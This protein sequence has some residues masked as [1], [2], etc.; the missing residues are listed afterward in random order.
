MLVIRQSS[1]DHLVV[2]T[3]RGEEF[4]GLL[5]CGLGLLSISMFIISQVE[6]LESVIPKEILVQL[7]QYP[8]AFG[9]VGIIIVFMQRRFIFH[10]PSAQVL[11][12]EG[13]KKDRGSKYS[14]FEKIE[15]FASKP[16][17]FAQLV[18]LDGRKL[19][20]TRGNSQDVKSIAERISE[21]T[22]L[23]IEHLNLKPRLKPS[24]PPA[25][26]PRAE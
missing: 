14:E 24:V 22:G 25:L 13:L 20:V 7:M 23:P 18:Y 10:R 8:L 19:L 5:F 15:L 3:S 21:F 2:G 16:Q 4:A 17:G 12:K 6:H 9:I 26:P 11:Y 1:D